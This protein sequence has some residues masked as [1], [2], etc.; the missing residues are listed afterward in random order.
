M[1]FSKSCMYGVRASVKLARKSEDGFVTIRELSSEL[2]ISFYFLTKILQ[3]LTRAEILES[4][5]GPNGG[6][7]LAKP[8]ASISFLDIV[9]AIDGNC[10]LQQ[11]AL[12]LPGCGV[13]K[14]CPLHEQWAVL[15][16]QMLVMLKSMTL[17]ELAG[18]AEKNLENDLNHPE[19]FL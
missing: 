3:Q 19:N 1:L 5:K 15:R 2:G 14:P 6:V 10:S 13:M 9:D 18:R 17:Q 8:A 12:G 16:D 7:K 11:C 4:Y